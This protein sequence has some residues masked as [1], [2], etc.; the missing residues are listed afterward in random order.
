MIISASYKTDIPAFYGK[1]FLERYRQGACITKNPYNNKAT[2]VSMR[3]QDVD[4]FIFWTRNAAPFQEVLSKLQVDGIPFVVQYTLTGYPRTLEEAVPKT[5]QAVATMKDIAKLY[6]SKTLVWRYDPIVVSNLTPNS[7]HV[8]QFDKLARE[9]RGATD[10]VITSFLSPY[11]KTLRRLSRA[12]NLML[13]NSSFEEKCNLL[14]QFREIACQNAMTL[15]LCAEPD[16]TTLQIPAA[17]CIDTQRISRI[18]DRAVVVEEMGT[19]PG[20]TC[21]KSRDIG[22]YDTCLQ[23]CIY[24]YATSS[25]H[26]AIRNLM[27]HNSKELTL[28]H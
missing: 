25:S 13:N 7:F 1:W 21:A 26:A 17:R 8:R 22:S 6:G 28:K 11:K 4:A 24:C 3:K 2:F 14:N 9:L 19:R 20:C 12:Q 5:G 23:G 16:Y 10:E 18:A 27:K 15:K